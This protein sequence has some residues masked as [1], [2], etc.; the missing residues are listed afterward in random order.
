MVHMKRLFS[1]ILFAIL[2]SDSFA[3]INA[4]YNFETGVPDFLSVNGDGKLE[5]SSV[6][7]KDGE[8]SVRFSWNGPAEIVFSNFSDIKASMEVNDAGLMMWVYNEQPMKEP[9]VFTFLD[10]SMNEICHFDFNADFKGW[11]AIWIKYIDMLSPYGHYGDKKLKERVT[12]TN[13]G[14]IIINALCIV[15]DA[16]MI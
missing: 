8:K 14:S 13:V 7:F 12:S 15:L 6:R 11:R 16:A 2:A 10:W 4:Q 3:A 9:I 1:I 5:C